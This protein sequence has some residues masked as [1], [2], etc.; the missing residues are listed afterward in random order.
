M[1]DI[2]E[3]LQPTIHLER[4]EYDRLIEMQ[5]NIES[6]D[7]FNVK[8]NSNIEKTGLIKEN[9]WYSQFSYYSI[10]PKDNGSS[11]TIGISRTIDGEIEYSVD[12]RIDEYSVCTPVNICKLVD[13]EKLVDASKTLPSITAYY[14][15]DDWKLGNHMF[16]ELCSRYDLL[17][18]SLLLLAKTGRDV[19]VKVDFS[20]LI[21]DMNIIQYELALLGTG[22]YPKE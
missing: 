2:P 22:A 19:I 14:D 12:V 5:Q 15:I 7:E 17:I 6:Y 16:S 13:G 10:A 9:G 8:I 3:Q 20:P 1:S 21:S 4:H 18:M 11:M